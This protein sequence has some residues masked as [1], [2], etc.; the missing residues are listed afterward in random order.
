MAGGDRRWFQQVGLFLLGLGL[1][2]VL[3]SGNL[4]GQP[5]QAVAQSSQDSSLVNLGVQS[6]RAGNF[7]QAIV[8]W[9]QALS[10]TSDP[11]AQAVIHSNLGQAYRRV[12]QFD[13]AIAQWEKAVQIYRAS[14]ASN[15]QKKI[16]ALLTEQAQAYGDLGQHRTAVDRLRTAINLAKSADDLRTEAAAQG[17]LGN[18]YWS[19]GT[20]DDALIAHEK[21]LGLACQINDL[22][23]VTTALNNL[24][25]VFASRAERF[26]FQAT[27]ASLEGDLMAETN[28][29]ARSTR[30]LQVALGAYQQSA[31]VSQQLGGV[32]EARALLNLNRLLEQASTAAIP[33]LPELDCNRL[34]IAALRS[35]P[36]VT[37]LPALAPTEADRERIAQN[38]ARIVALLRA[39]PNS[40]EKAYG[41]INLANRFLQT[42]NQPNAVSSPADLLQEA[43]AVARS[44]GDSR[45]ESFALGTLGYVYEI[46]RNYLQAMELTRQAQFVAQ[47]V[48]A[49]DS[50]YRWQWQTG[51]LMKAQQQVP[52]AIAAYERAIATLQSIRGDIIVTNKD[53]QFDFRD[54]VEPVYRELI[55]L[56]LSQA[57]KAGFPASHDTAQAKSLPV[58]Q[59]TENAQKV[60]NILEL[61]KLAELQNFFGDDCVQVARDAASAEQSLAQAQNQEP[62]YGIADA[63]AA[64]VYSV[65]LPEQTYLILRQP[66]GKLKQYAVQLAELPAAGAKEL[67]APSPAT[68]ARLQQHIDRLRSLLEKRSTEE[69]LTEAQMVYDALI[70]PM[71]TDLQA[72]NPKTLVFIHDDVLRKVPMGALHDGTQFLIEK[73]PVATTPS[74]SL[75]T[76]RPLDRRNL[77]ALILGLTVEQPPFAA[78]PNVGTEVKGV[79][80]IVGGTLLVDQAFTLDQV[81]SQLKETAYPIVHMATHGKFGADAN[82]TFLLAYKQRIT[83][84]ELDEILRTRQSGQPVELLTL[85]ACQTAAGDNRATLGIAGVAVRAGVKS[86]LATLWFINDQA[87]VPLIEEFY[88]QLLNTNVSKA[89]ALRQAQLKMIADRDYNHPAVW[90]PFV[91]IGNWL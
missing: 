40:Q 18:A 54:S 36:T 88:K 72:L 76:R 43:L 45:A 23:Y 86:A 52:E 11:S 82:N 20:Y 31:T 60:L 91:L 75:T 19:L 41:L 46:D 58:A 7:P 44:V 50:L 87:T 83:I 13:Q 10:Q 65:V 8:Q 71:E 32:A 1:C 17:A 6:Y 38:Q 9:K 69:Y 67:S 78:L 24:G 22:S 53:L 48:N 47:Q 57:D 12:G 35:P 16:A 28:F 39:E 73:Y 61:L 85:S 59:S 29:K 74:L 26:R 42:P 66:D 37:T 80:E 2:L 49:A 3:S 64:V 14:Q 84:N 21:S 34:N 63:T 90:S 25:N 62:T 77:R 55:S 81:Q 89:E 68:Q 4:G 70:R 15:H 5:H 56:L 33:T 51:R 30:D 27:A 79:R